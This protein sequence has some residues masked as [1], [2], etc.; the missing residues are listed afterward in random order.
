[1]GRV[2]ALE[3]GQLGT[4]W[5][6]ASLLAAG[7]VYVSVPLNLLGTAHYIRQILRGQVQP[8][9]ASWL[10]WS[11]A[12]AVVLAAE[13]HEG[14]GVRTVMTMAI[15]LGPS[16]VFMASFATRAAYW[17]LGSWDWACGAL[18]GAAIVLWAITDSA[19]L[20]IVFSILAD[21]LAAIPTIRKA[22]S[23]PQTE[24]PIFFALISLGGG[25]TLLTIQLWTFANSAFPIYIFVFPGI[26]AALIWRMQTAGTLVS[27]GGGPGG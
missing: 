9:R 1:V 2:A 5:K 22:I 12:P 7:F 16:L 17:T 8:N 11:I 6:G 25:V 23:H 13:L 24:N 20:A 10:L 26:L 4:A 14:V 27:R 15:V 3:N 21:A 18:S 19:D